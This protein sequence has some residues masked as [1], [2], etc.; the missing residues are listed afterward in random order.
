LVGVSGHE[1]FN[2]LLNQAI[3]ISKGETQ[4]VTVNDGSQAVV[5]SIAGGERGW[6]GLSHESRYLYRITGYYSHDK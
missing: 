4:H 1:A 6:N 3:S 5:G 2:K